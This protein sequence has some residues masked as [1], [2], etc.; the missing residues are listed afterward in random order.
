LAIKDLSRCIELDNKNDIAYF[1]RGWNYLQQKFVD[2]AVIDLT[3][4]LELHL[5]R[6]NLSE[7]QIQT[8]ASIVEWFVETRIAQIR[9]CIRKRQLEEGLEYS[10][11]L[12]DVVSRWEGHES[13]ELRA[14]IYRGLVLIDM[15]MFTEAVEN[16][17][18]VLEIDPRNVKA[19]SKRGYCLGKLG[20]MNEALED[21]VTALE[22]DSQ[23]SEA[24]K[25]KQYCEE[26]LGGAKRERE[27]ERE[28]AEKAEK[29]KDKVENNPAQEAA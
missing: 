26:V 10:E 18:V 13:D 22:W 8:R 21:Y 4:A 24:A 20:L 12:L 29:E 2:L 11:E 17:N 23:F 3:K 28:K 15:K 27:R 1:H 19:Y 7:K 16:F 6:E 25:G 14:L 9:R 5:L